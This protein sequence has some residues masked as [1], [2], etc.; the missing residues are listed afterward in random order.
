MKKLWCD[1]CGKEMG[2]RI[3]WTKEI[4]GFS[5]LSFNNVIDGIRDMDLCPECANELQNCLKQKVEVLKKRGR[6]NE[7]D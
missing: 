3:T 5:G 7:Q 1:L 2:A 4:D 6:L